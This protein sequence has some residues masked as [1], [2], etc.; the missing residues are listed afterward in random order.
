M[1][2]IDPDAA[3]RD[4][5]MEFARTLAP[6]WQAALGPELLGL[7]LIG[8]LAHGGFSRR[9]SDIDVAV[10][11][12]TGLSPQTLDALRRQATALSADWGPKVSVFWANRLFDAGRFPPLDRLDYLD[13]PVV[14]AECERATP[15]RPT[16]QE[17][18][19]YL[20]GAPFA[21]WASRARE[22]AAARALDAK[23]RKAYLRA[24]LY[25]AR[26]CFSYLTGLMAS[27]DD[28]V[29]YLREHP[30][31]GLDIVSIERALQC[32]RAAADPDSLFDLRSRLPA[33]ADVCA[34]LLADHGET[35]AVLK[36]D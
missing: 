1:N 14:L 35:V 2:S 36:G 13:R 5:A 18:H 20:R 6:V 15:A 31:P 27:N 10:I 8:S 33:Q 34:A 12:E 16:L 9:Y 17:I 28:A 3:A 4:A 23:G 19:D 30:P 24:L 25:P 29:A 7:Y 22:F 26:L 21:N 11:A 32:R